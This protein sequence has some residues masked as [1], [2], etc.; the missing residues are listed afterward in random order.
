MKI[1][2]ILSLIRNTFDIVFIRGKFLREAF[3]NS[4][5]NM[6]ADG[7]NEAGRFLQVQ[8]VSFNWYP[9]TVLTTISL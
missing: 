9:L 4:V 2:L 7:R 1:P 3:E 8:T 5:A 6:G